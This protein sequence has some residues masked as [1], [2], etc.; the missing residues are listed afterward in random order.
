[1][2]MIYWSFIISVNY[3]S[4][5]PNTISSEVILNMTNSGTVNATYEFVSQSPRDIPKRAVVFL[6]GSH[7]EFV[8]SPQRGK[9]EYLVSSVIT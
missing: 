3:G 7:I 6:G 4:L 2:E 5:I 9:S 1:M 8:L